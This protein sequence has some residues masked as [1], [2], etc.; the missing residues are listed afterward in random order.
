MQEEFNKEAKERSENYFKEECHKRDKWADA[1]DLEHMWLD[2]A[3]FGYN[4]AMNEQGYKV[5][6]AYDEGMA[7]GRDKTKLELI[8]AKEILRKVIDY[9]GQFCD[10]YPDC[11]TEAE[12]FLKEA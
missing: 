2:G 7:I 1:Y 6:S 3:E 10:D 9:L 5:S 8:K 11:V 4:K 12:H